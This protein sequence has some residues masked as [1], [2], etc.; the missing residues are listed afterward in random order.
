MKNKE[1]KEILKKLQA[2]KYQGK[3][4]RSL[5]LLESTILHKIQN[6][7]VDTEMNMIIEFG[8]LFLNIR[9][10]EKITTALCSLIQKTNISP[11]SS[12]DE[13]NQDSCVISDRTVYVGNLHYSVTLEDIKK[14]FKDCGDIK[15]IRFKK[16]YA[17]IDFKDGRGLKAALKKNN[18]Y[19]KG[20]NIVVDFKTLDQRNGK[21]NIKN[22]KKI[23]IGPI[24][25]PNVSVSDVRNFLKGCGMIKK[26][27]M[28]KRYAFVEFYDQ[29]STILALDTK[30]GT[31]FMGHKVAVDVS[32]D[33]TK[34]Y[35]EYGIYIADVDQK[36]VHKKNL[37]SFFEKHLEKN[38]VEN[39]TMDKRFTFVYFKTKE[40]AKSALRLNGFKINKFNLDMYP[41]SPY[42]DA[43][44]YGILVRN[45]HPQA[46]KTKIRE[47]FSKCGTIIRLNLSSERFKSSK[48]CHIFFETED[49]LENALKLNRTEFMDRR[50][51]VC[52][53]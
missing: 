5:D 51:Y 19:L 50:I 27:F 25:K 30:H 26:V 11:K 16:G 29:R 44:K 53:K 35:K 49:G 42:K 32:F 13:L 41:C 24:V 46:K 22:S 40:L 23:F 2:S 34:K 45:V 18:T 4:G 31:E 7:M 33:K 17:F 43:I 3:L 47:K 39:I 21:R 15:N 36:C 37:K 10:S 38:C 14:E 8:I 48:V 28:K 12:L 20:K 52:N 9:K 1:I 6:V